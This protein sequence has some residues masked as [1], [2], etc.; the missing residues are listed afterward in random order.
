M[1]VFFDTS[2]RNIQLLKGNCQKIY[3]E[4]AS[5]GHIHVRGMIRFAEDP[6]YQSS[7]YDWDKHYQQI[8][9]S[10]RASDI[11][12]FEVSTSSMSVGQLL[13]QALDLNK[14]VIALY[15]GKLKN[16]FLDGFVSSEKRFVLL[17]YSRDD[18]TT[19]LQYAFS[20]MHDLL[21]TRFTMIMP[22]DIA[23]YLQ[24]ISKKGINRSEFIRTL[25]R[26]KMGEK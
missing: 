4:I 21:D 8:L 15:T 16:T 3:N 7:E 5:L 25:I 6:F 17:E 22:Y 24:S 14:P 20:Y 2:P 9:N 10:L 18:I 23:S 19:T 11:A 26:E 1:K 13:Q 12:V